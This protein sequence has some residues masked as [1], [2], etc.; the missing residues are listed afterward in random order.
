MSEKVRI[1]YLDGTVQ[2]VKVRAA[3]RV[4]AEAHFKGFKGENVYQASAWLAWWSA[5]DQGKE[6][7]TYD[8]WL[9]KVD[10]FDDVTDEDDEESDPTTGATTP[11][12][13]SDTPRLTESSPSP[14]PLDS[15]SE[16]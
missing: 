1:T 6:D 5:K 12:S 4:A 11:A 9:K 14:S 10:D 13:T 2:T 7:C 15:P 8:E 3:A 16:S